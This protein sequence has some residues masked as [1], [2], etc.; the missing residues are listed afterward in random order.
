MARIASR[1]EKLSTAFIWLKFESVSNREVKSLLK[2]QDLD[3][4]ESKDNPQNFP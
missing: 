3:N 4:Q 1:L 2:Q